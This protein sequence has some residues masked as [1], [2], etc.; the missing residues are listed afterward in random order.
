MLLYRAEGEQLRPF[1]D[2]SLSQPCR[3]LLIAPTDACKIRSMLAAHRDI[4]AATKQRVRQLTLGHGWDEL[5]SIERI[6]Q[7]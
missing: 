4:S 3:C 1:V 6:L 2:G 7:A 5:A